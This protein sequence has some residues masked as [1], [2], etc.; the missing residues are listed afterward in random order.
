MRVLAHP[1]LPAAALA[2][3]LPACSSTPLLRSEA[4]ASYYDTRLQWAVLSEDRAL[5]QQFQMNPERS[6]TERVVAGVQ[7]PFAAAIETFTWPLGHALA[8]SEKLGAP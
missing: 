7:L 6:L 2:L 8:A 4:P 1:V 5:L 3:L